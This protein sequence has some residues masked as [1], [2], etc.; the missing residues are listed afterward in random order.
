MSHDSD[1]IQIP[2]LI[3]H[4]SGTKQQGMYQLVGVKRICDLIKHD[5][6]P[7]SYRVMKIDALKYQTVA[8]FPQKAE[9]GCQNLAIPKNSVHIHHNQKCQKGQ[10]KPT[11][12]SEVSE[13]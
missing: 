7:A 8:T 9:A 2:V 11:C 12:E 4:K 5:W 13:R 3:Q 1:D 6:A 10:G